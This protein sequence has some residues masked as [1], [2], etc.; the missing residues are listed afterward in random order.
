MLTPTLGLG[1]RHEENAIPAFDWP[2]LQTF[3]FSQQGRG[4][5]I[6]SLAFPALFPFGLA[7][8]SL[9]R[10]RSKELTFYDWIIHLLRFHDGRFA[11]HDR[12]RYAAF[13]LWMRELSSKRS[14]W[15]INKGVGSARHQRLSVEELRETLQDDNVNHPFL[16]CVIR[17]AST[18][19]GSRPFWKRRGRELSAHIKLLGKP[20]FFFTFSAA[21]TQWDSLQRH[22]P[23]YWIWLHADDEKR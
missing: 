23:D 1:I 13:N 7:D 11:R 8:W 6:F 10:Q 12:F 18:V 3:R 4:Q 15:L 14:K 17:C 22:L 19:K 20:A 2:R 5:R 21:D 16:N 9:P